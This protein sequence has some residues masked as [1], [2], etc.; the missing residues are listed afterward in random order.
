MVVDRGELVVT[1]A[2]QDP[3]FREN[4]YVVSDPPLVRFYAGVPLLTRT[5]MRSGRFA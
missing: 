5:A 1:D 3:R 2:S 4:P